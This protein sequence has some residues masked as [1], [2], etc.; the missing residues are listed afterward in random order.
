MSEKKLEK[1]PEREETIY[2]VH[3]C[4]FGQSK[5]GVR[6]RQLE[7]EVVHMCEREGARAVG[8]GANGLEVNQAALNEGVAR[9]VAEVTDPVEGTRPGEDGQRVPRTLTDVPDDGWRRVT[10]QE[11]KA[12]I[13]R[14]F[15]AKDVAALEQLYLRLHTMSGNEVADLMGKALPVTV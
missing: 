4:G 13:G 8:P 11:M 15:T 12:G 9:M 1:K 5:R 6:V 10:L 14:L 2:Q 7:T 3:L